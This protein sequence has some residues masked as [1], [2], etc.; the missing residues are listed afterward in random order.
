MPVSMLPVF[1]PKDSMRIR[2]L[3]RL[4]ND[5]SRPKRQVIRKRKPIVHGTRYAYNAHKCRCEECKAANAAYLRE[6]ARPA[7]IQ[8]HLHG[9]LNAY[10][11]LGCR[12]EKC[13][14]VSAAA[15]RARY[16]KCACPNCRRQVQGDRRN[17][18]CCEACQIAATANVR[19]E[20][21]REWS[22]QKRMNQE[23]CT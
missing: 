17:K 19:R 1:E 4:I 3:T 14:E 13:R 7:A 9:T 22:A 16:R 21:W 12:C 8:L 23:A 5:E 18:Y 11:H 2:V 10:D 15:K 20:Y 6:Q